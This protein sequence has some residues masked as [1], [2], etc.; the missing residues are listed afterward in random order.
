MP[1][2]QAEETR[3]S[4]ANQYRRVIDNVVGVVLAIRQAAE[5]AAPP[6]LTLPRKGGGNTYNAGPRQN[7]R[8][9]KRKL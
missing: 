4:C 1:H 3:P 2:T 6:S 5:Q 9:M 8:G 7:A